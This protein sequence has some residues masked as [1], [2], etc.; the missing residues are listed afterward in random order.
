MIERTKL[1]I[2][3]IDQKM[4]KNKKSYWV[5]DTGLGKFSIWD[6]GLYEILRDKAIGKEVEIGTESREANGKTFYNIVS[7]ESVIG[8]GQKEVKTEPI[9]ESAR[10]RRKTDSMLAAKDL[11]I[12]KI[13]EK[14]KLLDTANSFVEWIE[15]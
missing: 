8:E 3:R 12:A 4:T 2:F 9:N 14:E 15:N 11:V 13:I 1:T 6:V 7:F 5:A 10:L